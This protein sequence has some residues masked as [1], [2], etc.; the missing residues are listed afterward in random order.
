MNG[1]GGAQGTFDLSGAK[2]ALTKLAQSDDARRL[3]Q[4]LGQGGDVRDAAQAAA[5]GDPAALLQRMQQLM[6][7][8]EGAQLVERISR[9]AQEQGLTEK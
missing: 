9:Q 8:R 5:G 7:T 3:M 4:L 2:G 6:S 1:R